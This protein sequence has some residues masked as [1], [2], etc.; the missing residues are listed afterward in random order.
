MADKPDRYTQVADALKAV[1]GELIAEDAKFVAQSTGYVS[2][3]PTSWMRDALA[4][5]QAMASP[6]LIAGLA[7]H[8]FGEVDE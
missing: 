8:L 2:P 5:R 1:Y 7:K 3:D 6:G 4:V